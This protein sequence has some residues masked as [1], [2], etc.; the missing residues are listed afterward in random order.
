[1][2]MVNYR[3]IL[4]WLI[5]VVCT[6]PIVS[7]GATERVA[8]AYT[9]AN[10]MLTSIQSWDGYEP[11]IGLNFY[12]KIDY[13]QAKKIHFSIEAG[14]A[15]G[16]QD[17]QIE[18][19]DIDGQIIINVPLVLS[20]ESLSGEVHSDNGTIVIPPV[21]EPYVRLWVESIYE[22]LNGRRYSFP[23]IISFY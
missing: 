15:W 8:T 6:A 22:N 7:Y 5:W 20:I 18:C 19:F 17:I 4:R 1:M 3:L 11:I 12:Q 2:M 9:D 23:L 16:F 14:V 10:G 13:C 21:N